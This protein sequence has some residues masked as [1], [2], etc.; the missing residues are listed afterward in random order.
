M[1]LDEILKLVADEQDKAETFYVENGP[2]K[3]EQ[4]E[5]YSTGV[6]IVA[7]NVDLLAAWLEDWDAGFDD[8]PKAD[9]RAIWEAS[10]FHFGI[11]GYREHDAD[12]WWEHEAPN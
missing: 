12:F 11:V 7:M 4:E 3:H 10:G 6:S 2:N 1:T 5:Y 8:L 9:R